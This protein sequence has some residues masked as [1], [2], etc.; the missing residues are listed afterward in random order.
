MIK[1]FEGH[2]PQLHPD[3]RVAENATLVGQVTLEA[4]SSVW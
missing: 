1:S 2:T 4:R 3:A